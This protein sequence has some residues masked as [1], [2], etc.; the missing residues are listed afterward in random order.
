MVPCPLCLA[1]AFSLAVRLDRDAWC[2]AAQVSHLV[3]S[4]TAGFGQSLHSPRDLASSRLAW[5]TRRCSSLRSSVW[6]LFWSYSR[7]ACFL[8]STSAGVGSGRRFDVRS[9]GAAFLLGFLTF[10]FLGGFRTGGFFVFW[11]PG[12]FRVG[13]WKESIKSCGLEGSI[14]LIPAPGGLAPGV[15]HHHGSAAPS[16]LPHDSR[17][18]NV[19]PGQTHLADGGWKQPCLRPRLGI[20]PCRSSGGGWKTRFISPW[21]DG[22]LLPIPARGAAG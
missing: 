14:P 21:Q 10:G 5:A 18:R 8:A 6:R 20:P 7:R 11:G 17:I 3:R 16:A 19:D 9:F 15:L 1:A 12:F 22:I 4:G 2:F 13:N